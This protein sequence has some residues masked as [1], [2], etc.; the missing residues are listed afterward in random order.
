MGQLILGSMELSEWHVR[1]RASDLCSSASDIHDILEAIKLR[2]YEE[3]HDF[4]GSRRDHEK[5]NTGNKMLGKID[6]IFDKIPSPV[7]ESHR[8]HIKVQW[9][10]GNPDPGFS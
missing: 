9:N 4:G 3:T 10:K 6:A 2:T 8:V 5:R 7:L 1:P